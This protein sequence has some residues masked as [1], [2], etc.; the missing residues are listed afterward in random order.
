M[1][2]RSKCKTHIDIVPL[3]DV[4]TALIFFFI[5][6]MNFKSR[7]I[8][9]IEPPKIKSAGNINAQDDIIIAI[10]KDGKIFLNESVVSSSEFEQAIKRASE[11]DHSQSV[12]I[13]ADENSELKHLAYVFD[14]C[15]QHN[16]YK[17]RLQ[18]R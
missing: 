12:L 13:I 17:L 2:T 10:N 5:V 11:I 1:L 4:L 7:S 15:K 8:V 6:T 14:C 16:L 3:I 9:A 18:A